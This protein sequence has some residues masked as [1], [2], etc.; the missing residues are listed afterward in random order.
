M[1]IS[2]VFFVFLIIAV[3]FSMSSCFSTKPDPDMY[4]ETEGKTEILYYYG[5]RYIQTELFVYVDNRDIM[6]KAG[7]I[8]NSCIFFPGVKF[9]KE[10]GDA[11]PK[12]LFYEDREY[13]WIRED[14]DVMNE[15]VVLDGY[16]K[17]A[18]QS[19]TTYTEM[20]GTPE[21]TLESVADETVTERSMPSVYNSYKLKF[22]FKDMPNLFGMIT[23]EKHGDNLYSHMTSF[24]YNILNEEF[25]EKMSEVGINVGELTDFPEYSEDDYFCDVLSKEDIEIIK[26]GATLEM[27]ESVTGKLLITGAYDPKIKHYRAY[28]VKYGDMYLTTDENEYVVECHV[29]VREESTSYMIELYTLFELSNN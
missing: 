14:I 22:R 4:I 10:K 20:R 24:D 5:V 21:F 29:K 11:E 1:K 19:E 7:Y 18:Y 28:C 17:S 9:Y 6:E 2:K 15:A 27:L 8:R 16:Y 23:I 12:Y 25:S 3:L 26:N 13:I